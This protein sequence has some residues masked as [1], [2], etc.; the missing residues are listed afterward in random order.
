MKSNILTVSALVLSCLLLSNPGGCE[1]DASLEFGICLNRS[2]F[3]LGEFAK[4][5]IFVRNTGPYEIKTFG[6]VIDCA[7]R[8]VNCGSARPIVI[9]KKW[10]IL[11]PG[12]TKF[13]TTHIPK[14]IGIAEQMVGNHTVFVRL[15]HTSDGERFEIER[16]LDYTIL[17]GPS[18][19]YDAF[20]EFWE[21]K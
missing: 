19:A 6:P 21:E 12:E 20:D 2:R 15:G 14:D 7:P 3:R 11:A 8:F 16:R 9:P 1:T 5:E 13:L 18:G 17:P 4:I 10:Q